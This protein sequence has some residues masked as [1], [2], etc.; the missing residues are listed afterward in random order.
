ML[1]PSGQPVRSFRLS[2]ANGETEQVED[3]TRP[4]GEWSAPWLAPGTYNVKVSA[5]EGS[6]ERQ[7]EL[8]PGG[9]VNVELTLGGA[10]A[11]PGVARAEPSSGA[12]DG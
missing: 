12:H 8:A 4:S 9:Q 7:V 10:A 1:A 11:R 2:Y 3:V 5:E 6:A